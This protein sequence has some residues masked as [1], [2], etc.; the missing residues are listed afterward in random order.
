MQQERQK[1]TS[2]GQLILIKLICWEILS[3][4]SYSGTWTLK[5][6]KKMKNQLLYN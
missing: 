2:N 6:I 1:S 4:Q 5:K 3:L